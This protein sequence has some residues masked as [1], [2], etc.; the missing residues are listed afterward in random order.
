MKIFSN[1][2]LAFVECIWWNLNCWWPRIIKSIT[3]EN[4]STDDAWRT[5]LPAGGTTAN[6]SLPWK[7]IIALC[8]QISYQAIRRWTATWL[9]LGCFTFGFLGLSI[10]EL[11]GSKFNAVFSVMSCEWGLLSKAN[12]GRLL[13]E[14]GD[15]FFGFLLGS[16]PHCRERRWLNSWVLDR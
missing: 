3:N 11:S 1:V 15:V 8:Y 12:P 16:W 2:F 14:D 9:S 4:P 6:R 5:A 10:P 7:G 13:P